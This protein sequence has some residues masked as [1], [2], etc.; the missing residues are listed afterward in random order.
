MIRERIL[1]IFQNLDIDEP[2]DEDVILTADY[3]EDKVFDSITFVLLIVSL[4]DE[5]GVEIDGEN[6]LIENLSNFIAIE[7]L[8]SNLLAER[9]N[10]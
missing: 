8:I 5:F 4:E 10:E 1:D 2:L 7:K 9:D 6:M 3:V